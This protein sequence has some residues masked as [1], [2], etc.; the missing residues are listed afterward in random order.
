MAG[1]SMTRWA[2]KRARNRVAH[3]PGLLQRLSERIRGREQLLVRPTSGIPL[4]LVTYPRGRE[5]VARQLESA[6]TRTLSTLPR[7]L[8]E[9]YASVLEALPPIA[10][11]LLRPRNAC[12]CLGHFH[13]AGTE[14]R[15]TLRLAGDLGSPVAEIDL[16]YESI[17]EW[18][19]N[20]I[21]SL[22]AGNLGSRLADLRFEAALLSVLLHELHHLAAPEEAEREIREASNNFYAGVVQEFV[23]RESGQDYGM[24]GRKGFGL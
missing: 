12:T 2:R 19:P 24:H 17:R 3:P 13:P 10:V 16:A 9:P 5:M 7:E 8:T 14:S 23:K 6:Y 18:D 4:L 22:A 20:P 21:S 11:V 15:L 1:R